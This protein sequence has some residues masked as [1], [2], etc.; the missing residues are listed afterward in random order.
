MFALTGQAAYLIAFDSAN[1]WITRLA[2][3]LTKRGYTPTSS[4]DAQAWQTAEATSPASVGHSPAT[5]NSSGAWSDSPNASWASWTISTSTRNR[6]CYASVVEQVRVPGWN[7]EIRLRIPLDDEPESTPTPEPNSD[8]PSPLSIEDR[9]RSLGGHQRG[10]IPDARGPEPT[11]EDPRTRAEQ[12]QGVGTSSWLPA[13]T[14]TWPLTAPKGSASGDI[15]N[16]AGHQ[17]RNS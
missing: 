3:G 11:K 9:L 15:L 6:P 16:V 7:V 12:P 17:I 1:G 4:I 5:T 13:R 2:D 14:L 10:V 8:H